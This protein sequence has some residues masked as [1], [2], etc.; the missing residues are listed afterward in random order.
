MNNLFF[1]D[2]HIHGAFG[3]NFNTANYSEIKYLLEK[4]YKKNI[5]GICPTLV[6]DTKE[7]LTR[8]LEVIKKIKNE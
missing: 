8:Q 6:G 7:N 1:I 3:V 4:L 5:K 2:T